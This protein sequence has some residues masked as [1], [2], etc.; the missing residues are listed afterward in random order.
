MEIPQLSDDCLQELKQ[1]EAAYLAY[2]EAHAADPKGLKDLG[3]VQVLTEQE[4]MLSYIPVLMGTMHFHQH[5]FF[6]GLLAT[7][8]STMGDSKQAGKLLGIGRK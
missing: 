1:F 3:G 7:L 4:K 8:C 6:F 5:S 2:F